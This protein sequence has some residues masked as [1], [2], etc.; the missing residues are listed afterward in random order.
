[1]LASTIARIIIVAS[2]K[3]ATGKLIMNPSKSYAGS[4]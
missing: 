3:G 1:M 4:L 2:H